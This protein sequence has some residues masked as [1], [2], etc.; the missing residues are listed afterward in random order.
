LPIRA[1]LLD[2]AV[3][4]FQTLTWV[5][6]RLCHQQQVSAVV[7]TLEVSMIFRFEKILS[8]GYL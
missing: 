7:M 2:I 8:C 1:R 4:L 3:P 6:R 5:H